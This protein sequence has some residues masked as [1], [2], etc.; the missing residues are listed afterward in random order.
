MPVRAAAEQ[1]AI[2]PDG[3]GFN[4]VALGLGHGRQYPLEP[5]E[6]RRAEPFA[7]QFRQRQGQGDA[8]PWQPEQKQQPARCAAEQS[9]RQQEAGHQGQGGQGSGAAV[10]EIGNAQDQGE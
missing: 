5:G 10:G 1:F 7:A 3:A 9:H 6:Q 4:G 2:P 8:Q